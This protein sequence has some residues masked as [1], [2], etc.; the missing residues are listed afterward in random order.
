M[1]EAVFEAGWQSEELMPHHRRL[2]SRKYNGK[3]RYPLSF[4]STFAHHERG[5]KIF[6]VKKGYDY[7]KGRYGR[8]QT[9]ITAKPGWSWSR[10]ATAAIACTGESLLER[11]SRSRLSWST[12]SSGTTS[13]TIEDEGH[14]P[15]ADYAFDNGFLSLNLTR[16]LEKRDKHWTSELESS[17]H[18]NGKGSW[19]RVDEVA[20]ELKQHHAVSFRRVEYE[21]RSGETKIRWGF[22]KVVRLKRYGKKRILIVHEFEDLSDTPRFLVT[23]AHHREAKGILMSW[24]YRWTCELFHEFDG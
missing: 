14:Y 12:S 6:G 9:V 11:N 21:A 17:R 2:I 18:M 15:E 23:N 1:H 16:E 4:D 24:D 3:G 7:V 10:S 13:G 20:A 19:R 5:P 8:I 22:S